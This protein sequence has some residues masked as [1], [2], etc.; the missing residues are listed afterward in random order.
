MAYCQWHASRVRRRGDYRGN[1][2]YC[3]ALL[4]KEE[5]CGPCPSLDYNEQQAKHLLLEQLPTYMPTSTYFLQSDGRGKC[6][7]RDHLSA[8]QWTTVRQTDEQW[9]GLI[10]MWE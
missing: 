4:K 8:T 6:G 9:C 3:F 5:G 1:P 2:Y 10:C 7:P